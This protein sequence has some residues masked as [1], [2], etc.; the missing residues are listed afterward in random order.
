MWI[1]HGFL[2]YI[3]LT[4]YLCMYFKVFHLGLTWTISKLKERSPNLGHWVNSS[5]IFWASCLF[6]WGSCSL[7]LSKVR[8]TWQYFVKMTTV[9]ICSF[10]VS[11]VELVEKV[12]VWLVVSLPAVFSTSL[13][14]FAYDN[15]HVISC[16]TLFIFR[17]AWMTLLLECSSTNHHW[18][19]TSGAR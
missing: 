4:I 16:I 17:E 8:A 13:Q 14:S 15:V 18:W 9:F 6:K 7:N 2:G 12:L 1:D 5:L 19:A 3:S 11:R 10:T